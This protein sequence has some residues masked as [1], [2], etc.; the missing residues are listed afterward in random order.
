MKEGGEKGI[1]V[2]KPMV[3]LLCSPISPQGTVSGALTVGI[4]PHTGAIGVKYGERVCVS[5]IGLAMWT[6]GYQQ[7]ASQDRY[8]DGIN[9][10]WFMEFCPETRLQCLNFIAS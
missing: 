4:E 1:R 2:V 7:V 9:G 6:K 3:L 5:N 8:F 10:E